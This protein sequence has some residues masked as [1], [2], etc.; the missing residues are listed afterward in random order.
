MRSLRLFA[1]CVCLTLGM[2]AC[3]SG[4]PGSTLSPSAS[5]S[6]GATAFPHGTVTPSPL[7]NLPKCKP[8]K[9]LATPDWV[10]KDLPLPDGT[11][12]TK[13]IASQGGYDEGLFILPLSTSEIATFVL[14][15]WPKAGYQLGR[16]D[17][18]PGEVEDQ[19][20]KF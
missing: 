7:S 12:F 11:F 17:A 6:T 16:G 4:G 2:A 13:K 19:F 1:L 18:E 14:K 3:G 15:E 8:Q 9:H 10:P 5:P 20:A